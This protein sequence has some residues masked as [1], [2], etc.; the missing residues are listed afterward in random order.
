M[1]HQRIAH[2]WNV[3]VLGLAVL[4]QD[5]LAEQIAHADSEGTGNITKHVQPSDIAFVTLNLAKPVL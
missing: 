5:G 3:V 1:T 2:G 4:D